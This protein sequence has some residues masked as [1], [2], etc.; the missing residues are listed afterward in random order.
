M[1]AMTKTQIDAQHHQVEAEIEATQQQISELQMK[2][3]KLEQT[4]SRLD[5]HQQLV[6]KR[7]VPEYA[8]WLP[9]SRKQ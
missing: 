8:S 5:L 6:G 9:F 7:T 1:L 4:L 2:E 3:A